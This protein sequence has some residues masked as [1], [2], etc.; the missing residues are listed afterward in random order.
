MFALFVLFML[1]S[2]SQEFVL[3][4]GTSIIATD[5]IEQDTH[6]N[7]VDQKGERYRIS[8][9]LI[10]ET[11]NNKLRPKQHQKMKSTSIKKSFLDLPLDNKQGAVFI[12]NKN[13]LAY[14]KNHSLFYANDAVKPSKKPDIQDSEKLLANQT[15]LNNKYKTKIQKLKNK[16]SRLTDQKMTLKKKMFLITDFVERKKMN[17]N[18]SVL[19]SD[20]EAENSKLMYL[21]KEAVKNGANIRQ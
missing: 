1:S 4:D 17:L 6:F 19:S 13:L 21:K 14:K 7:F 18:I 5:W 10:K 3:I 2:D 9:K 20:I 11:K 15:K 12:N 8:K 16:I